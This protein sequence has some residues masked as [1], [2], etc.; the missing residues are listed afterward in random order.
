MQAAVMKNALKAKVQIGKKQLGMADDAYRALLARLANGKTSS[1]QLTVA[2]L[3]RVLEDMKAKGFKPTQPKVGKRPRPPES[4]EALMG[5]VEALLA[6][7][8]CSWAYADGM[9][10][11]MF[12]VEKVDWL[13]K[14]QL[15]R[16]VAALTYDARRREA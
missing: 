2:E 14:S 9:A 8:G 6:S 11:K 13:D 12:N 3:E 15:Y 5:K 7:A 1:T 10:R 16:V 4:R